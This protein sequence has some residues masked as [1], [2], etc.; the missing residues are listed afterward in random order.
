MVRL[1]ISKKEFDKIFIQFHKMEKGLGFVEEIEK[2]PSER[3]ICYYAHLGCLGVKDDNCRR[4]CIRNG[5]SEDD[6]ECGIRK[7][8]NWY[9]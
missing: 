2:V 3:S 8:M 4:L 7:L 1:F 6:K 9:Y 5:Y